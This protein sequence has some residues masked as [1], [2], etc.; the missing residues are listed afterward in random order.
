MSLKKIFLILC[1]LCII[2]LIWGCPYGS[3]VPLSASE[4]AEIDEDL[5]GDWTFVDKRGN[6]ETKD[7]VIS[8]IRFN[9]HE[10]LIVMKKGDEIARMRAFVTEI[11]GYRFLNCQEIK[12]H[13]RE[14]EDYS[15]IEYRIESKDEVLL[16]IV[17]G[18]LFEE[19][20]Q[21]TE[22]LFDFV[23]SNIDNNKLY[24]D[25]GTLQRIVK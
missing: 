7:G 8:F 15:F 3:K 13:G 22:A 21:S 18:E 23:K 16:R 5:L 1:L 11:D 17:E 6:R 20:F 24:D 14:R 4:V 25:L 9:D 12:E 2:P 19:K 10:F